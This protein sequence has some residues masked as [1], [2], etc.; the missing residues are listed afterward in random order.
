M[1]TRIFGLV[2]ICGY[3]LGAPGAALL[4]QG[5]RAGLVG[6]AIALPDSLDQTGVGAILQLQPV[7]WLTLAAHPTWVRVSGGGA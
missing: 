5:V 6:G 3:A 1:R 7:S 2:L 4:A